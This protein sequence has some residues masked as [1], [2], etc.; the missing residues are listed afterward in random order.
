MSCFV[1]CWVRL[2]ASATLGSSQVGL[3]A[4]GGHLCLQRAP[5]VAF[6]QCQCEAFLLLPSQPHGTGRRWEELGSRGNCSPNPWVTPRTNPPVRVGAKGQV[7]IPQP[8]NSQCK[9]PVSWKLAYAEGGE[10][11]PCCGLVL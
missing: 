11:F 7:S 4:E 6:H 3:P 1:P 2:S 9:R 5:A 10:G 8:L